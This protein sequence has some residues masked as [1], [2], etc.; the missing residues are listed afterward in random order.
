MASPTTVLVAAAYGSHGDVQPMY[1]LAI[2][3]ARKPN[4]RVHFF[5]SSKHADRLAARQDATMLHEVIVVQE[6]DV[7]DKWSPGKWEGAMKGPKAIARRWLLTARPLYALMQARIA[8]SG[9]TVIVAHPLN[10]AARLLHD[11]TGLPYATVA[12][13]PWLMRSRTQ[14]YGWPLVSG[15]SWTPAWIKEMGYYVIDLLIDSL[16]VPGELGLRSMYDDLVAVDNVPSSST[17]QEEEQEREGSSSSVT[18]TITCTDANNTTRPIPPPPRRILDRWFHSPMRILALWPSWYYP[19]QPDWPTQL[20]NCGGFPLFDEKNDDD[21]L[22]SEEVAS[23]VKTCV[24]DKAPL[25][26]VTPGTTNPLLCTTAFF[27]AA[28]GAAQEAAS[29]SRPGTQTTTIPVRVLLLT[30]HKDAVLA[31]NRYEAMHARGE[32]LHASYAPLSGVLAHAKHAALVH[33]GGIG[34]VAQALRCGVPSVVLANA[35][36]QFDNAWAV[37]EHLKCGVRPSAKA[38]VKDADVAASSVRAVL[39]LD[40][41]YRTRAQEV[42]ARIA[43]DSNGRTTIDRAADAVLALT[44]ADAAAASL[45][46]EEEA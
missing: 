16:V 28:L 4:T 25:L 22:G 9:S 20:V 15:G 35:F 21:D 32:A 45:D 26:V 39:E 30:P 33:H 2:A 38:F 19:Q 42:S 43:E 31:T 1:A 8:T 12:L 5:V 17:Q 24:D 3:L 23:F 41:I 34:T 18:I 44:T 13:A 11:A 7:D 29:S 27:D 6:P 37:A 14:C 40:S 10:F 46:K 36:D